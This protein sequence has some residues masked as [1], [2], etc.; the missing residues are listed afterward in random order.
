M[1]YAAHDDVE[2]D[3]FTNEYS[4]YRAF[5]PPVLEGG[6]RP[7]WSVMI[8]TYNCAKYLRGVLASVLEQDMGP[9]IMQIEV[10]DDYS[11]DDDPGTVVEELGRGRV[12]FYRQAA[13][14]GITK[15]FETCLRRSRGKLI[16]L[17]HGDDYVRNGFYRKMQR[18]FEEHTQIGA[19]FCRQIFIDEQ[20]NSQGISKLEREE[21]GI[22]DN[23][24]ERISVEQRIMTPSIVVRREVYERLGGFDQRLICSEDWEMWVRIAAHYPI[25]YEVEPLAVYRMHLLSNTGRHV[26]T[27]EDLQYTRRC[28]EIFKAYLPSQ[29]ADRLS[30]KARRTY[31]V[32]GLK[33]AYAMFRAGDRAAGRAQ[34][35]EA[36]KCS[37]SLRVIG[38]LMWLFVRTGGFW[39]R[40]RLA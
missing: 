7:L 9:D 28:I 20:G 33:A 25:W 21:S 29:T 32:S 3:M 15:N 17:L 8:P 16:H 6:S 4:A 30:N 37:Y 35:R 13:N 26:R 24:L 39:I 38:Q 11:T 10:V 23:W 40:Q 31:A 27:G 18:A 36:L 2:N 22:L 19:A 12:G 14:M 34:V 1:V 5:I